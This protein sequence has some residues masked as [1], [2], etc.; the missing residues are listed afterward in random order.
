MTC[1]RYPL[2]EILL[3]DEKLVSAFLLVVVVLRAPDLTGRGVCPIWLVRRLMC[4]P[5]FFCRVGAGSE[6]KLAIAMGG[7]G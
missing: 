2:S 3:Y 1:V 5:L 6:P 4:T 7:H